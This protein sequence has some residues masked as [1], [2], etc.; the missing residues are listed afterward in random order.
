MLVHMKV[1]RLMCGLYIITKQQQAQR[2]LRHPKQLF[3]GLMTERK[4]CC[5]KYF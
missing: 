1:Q 4:G 3:H 2:G 5:W